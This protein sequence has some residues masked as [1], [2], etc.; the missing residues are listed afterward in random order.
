LREL[1]SPAKSGF[2]N[3]STFAKKVHSNGSE[4]P[5]TGGSSAEMWFTATRNG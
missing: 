1:I 2:R 4:A 5:R 3:S